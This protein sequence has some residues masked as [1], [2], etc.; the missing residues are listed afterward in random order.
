MAEVVINPQRDR[1]ERDGLA[2]G[3]NTTTGDVGPGVDQI[4]IVKQIVGSAVLLKNDD[5]VF[6]LSGWWRRFCDCRPAA[7]TV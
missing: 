7:A 5:D 6:D 4:L 3:I 1:R 2:Q